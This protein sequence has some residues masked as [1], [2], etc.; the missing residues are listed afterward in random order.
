MFGTALVLKIYSEYSIC[1]SENL[2]NGV[3]YEAGSTIAWSGTE[4]STLRLRRT[5]V[6]L[7][8]RPNEQGSNN[9]G[10]LSNRELVIGCDSPDFE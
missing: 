4:C 10:T 5:S 6:D 2:K 7:L 8:L 9:S 1:F 3:K